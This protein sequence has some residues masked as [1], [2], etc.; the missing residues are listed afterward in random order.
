MALGTEFHSAMEGAPINESSDNAVALRAMVANVK[1][2]PSIAP[3][4][5]GAR[6]EVTFFSVDSQT[7]LLKRCRVDA[8]KEE[9]V[10]DYKTTRDASPFAFARDC[11]K[12]GYRISA[13]Y[14]LEIVSEVMGSMHRDFRIVAVENTSPFSAALYKADERS[15]FY[16]EEDVRSALT[17]IAKYQEEGDDAW[18]GYPLGMRE[19]MI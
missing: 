2:H 17:A 8:Y 5:A 4:I 9:I 15:I 1:A 14:Y 16:G 11:M 7:G 12:L 3:L 13:A 18:T 19:L 10:I 6:H